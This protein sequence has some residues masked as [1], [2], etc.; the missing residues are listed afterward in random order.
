MGLKN[1]VVI[2][3]EAHHCYREKPN[4]EDISELKGDDKKEAETENEAARLWING[5]ECFKRKLGVRAVYDLPRSAEDIVM[6]VYEIGYKKPPQKYRFQKGKSGN[7]RGRPKGNKSKGHLAILD[8]LLSEKIEIRESG[9]QKKVTKLEAF[10]KKL[11]AD[12]MN[13]DIFRV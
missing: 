8:Q 13:G 6:S 7:P 2:N 9:Q 10:L 4:N 3:D 5:I 12:S 1:I 11:F